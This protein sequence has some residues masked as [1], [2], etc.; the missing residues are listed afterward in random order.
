[1]SWWKK[2]IDNLKAKQQSS[3]Q[4]KKSNDEGN[5]EDH[6]DQL[7][8]A[9]LKA[10]VNYRSSLPST[11]QE[12]RNAPIPVRNGEEV[13]EFI[14][15]SFEAWGW[16]SEEDYIATLRHFRDKSK[17]TVAKKDSYTRRY[18]S[19]LHRLMKKERLYY[20]RVLE[21]EYLCSVP[22]VLESVKYRR[23]SDTFI[24]R[25]VF[26]VPDPDNPGK[27]KPDFLE[28]ALQEEWVRRSFSPEMVQHIINLDSGLQWTPVPPSQKPVRVHN[29][30]IV[31]VRWRPPYKIRV[32]ITTSQSKKTTT[33]AISKE[34][35]IVPGVW[36]AKLAD[37][38]V[39]ECTVPEEFLVEKFGKVYVDEVKKLRRGFVDVPVGDYKPSSL[40]N[41]P[42]LRVSGAPILQYRQSAG[43]NLCVSK[44]FASALFAIG[45]AEEAK[46]I[47][48][49]GEDNLAGN[50]TNAL[51]QIQKKAIS[52]LPRWLQPRKMPLKFVWQDDLDDSTILLAVLTASDGHRNHAITIHGGFIYDANEEVALP[53][54]QEALDYCVSTEVQKSKFENFRRGVL[55]SYMGTKEV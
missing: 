30:P 4:A 34:E 14:Q 31:R 52:V 24:G 27:T 19:A 43:Q 44:S 22:A 8:I 33:D 55:F 25:M 17:K 48:A 51:I 50:V 46:I 28:E 18:F 5:S 7:T 32:P 39:K 3:K 36:F 40:Q 16:Y 37:S 45:F 6:Q 13:E 9:S 47:N 26:E 12:L 29:K 10:F 35:R 23:D 53:L 21:A 1:M 54:N 49:F 42:H 2:D 38:D 15:R 20:R 11:E 41:Y